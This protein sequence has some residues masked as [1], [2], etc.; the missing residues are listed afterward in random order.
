MNIESKWLEDF[1]ALAET[2]NFSGAAGLR[3]ITQPAFSR[4][5]RML[6]QSVGA[7]LVD[8]SQ[9]PVALTASGRI[10]RVTARTLVN[11]MVEGISHISA[12]NYSDGSV[13]RIASAHSLALNLTQSIQ[14]Q[15]SDES[16]PMLSV[17][18]MNVDE[19]VDALREGECDVLLAFDNE[20][21]KL[22]P[23]EHIKVGTA[24]LLPV[25]AADNK[26]Q[27]I[28]HFEHDNVP[29]LAFTPTSYMGR[30]TETV[31]HEVSLKPVFLSSMV[32]MLKL[33]ALNGL[34]V[35]WLPDFAIRTEL[36]QGRLVVMKNK[37][38]NRRVSYYAYRYQ[39]R[40]HPSGEKIWA[41]LKKIAT[42]NSFN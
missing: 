25:C 22:A 37:A 8:R 27:P 30:Q 7:E 21:L 1:L 24:D 32:D 36:S 10:F 23:Y 38:L 26:G 34:G 28:Y 11:Q 3:N 6:E 39:S 15:F 31:R 12:L 18:A 42:D 5:I 14:A 41:A 9:T 4:R 17:D 29:W 19:A 40:L 13:V 20:H 2:R 16:R 35:A 33:Q